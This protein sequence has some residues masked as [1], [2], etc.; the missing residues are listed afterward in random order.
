MNN[1]C[2]GQL[3]SRGLFKVFICTKNER[4]YFCISVL[5]YKKKSNRKSGVRES[6]IVGIKC[7]YCFDLTFLVVK[8]EIQKY[9]VWFLVQMNTLKGP[10][11]FK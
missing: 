11:E 1:T 7:P 6:K 10:F 5:A 8:V 9:F 2:K 3:I 4:K